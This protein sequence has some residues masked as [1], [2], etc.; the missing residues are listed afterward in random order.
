MV[1]FGL[2]EVITTN[3]ELVSKVAATSLVELELLIDGR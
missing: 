2:I 3:E 1:V